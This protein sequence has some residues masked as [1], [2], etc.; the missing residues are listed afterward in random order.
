LRF[1]SSFICS[2]ISIGGSSSDG[3]GSGVG[4]VDEVGSI[5]T[6]AFAFA[7]IMLVAAGDG[8]V[9]VGEKDMSASAWDVKY[10]GSG[11]LVRCSV[12]ERKR[13]G[14]REERQRW[15]SSEAVRYHHRDGL[16]W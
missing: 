3:G 15:T 7:L 4:A 13:R 8:T 2:E 11:T 6:R 1:S 14:L 10:A 16:D 9:I 12:V 5:A